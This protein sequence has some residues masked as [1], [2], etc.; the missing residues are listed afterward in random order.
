MDE[1]ITII[2]NPEM[3]EAEN[4]YWLRK[5]GIDYIEQ[6]GNRWW[7]DYNIHDPGITILEALSYALTELGYRTG[8]DIQDL[9]ADPG[10]KILDPDKQGFY[11]A[12]EILTV[13]PWTVTDY[14]KL[15]VDVSG[16]KNAWLI[17][18]QC[19]CETNLYVDCKKSELSYKKPKP[20]EKPA[21]H[22]V[23]PKGLYDVFL[24]FEEEEKAGDLNSGKIKQQ[25][26]VTINNKP[27][28]IVVELRLPAWPQVDVLRKKENVWK[29]FCGQKSSVEKVKATV[30]SGNKQDNIDITDDKLG[31]ALRKPMYVTLEVE[32][33]PDSS[34]PATEKIIWED[35]PFNLLLTAADIKKQLKVGDLRKVFEDFSAGGMAARYHERI[36]KTALTI[37]AVNQSLQSH[38]NL[39]ED[40]CTVTAIGIEEVAVC[41]DIE[42]SGDADIEK[43][44]AEVYYKVEN[45]FSPDIKFYSLKER[46][47]ARIPVDEIFEGPP[48]QFGF[49]DT[50]EIEATALKAELHTS[51]VINLLMDIEGVKAVKNLVL[52][53]YDKEGKA[54][55]SQQWTLKITPGHQPRLFLEASKFLV[56]KNNLTFLPDVSELMDTL[57]VIRGSLQRP[58]LKDHDLNLP[59][60][61]GKYYDWQ[62]YYPVQ[63]SFPLT[64][65]IGYEGLP[66]HAGDLRRAQASQ[67]KSYLLFYEQMLVN[68][69]AQLAHI[70][71]LFALDTSVSHSYFSRL[72]N[73]NDIAG[74]TSLYTAFDQTKL[75][76]LAE[77]Q[78]EFL[79]RRNRF[80]DHLLARFAESFT[81]YTLLLY[82]YTGQGA[83]AN[84]IL[85][86]DK[87]AF[88]KIYPLISA[89]RARAFNYKDEGNT[90]D[91]DNISGLQKRISALLGFEQYISYFDFV[92]T[93]NSGKYKLALRSGDA[94][95]LES[96]TT[97]TDIEK[98]AGSEKS[99]KI[100]D[101]IA[102]HISIPERFDISSSQS[103]FK[104]NLTNAGGTKIASG[105]QSY[106][107]KAEAEQARDGI[108][109]FAKKFLAQQ[110]VLLVEHLLLRPRFTP[111]TLPPDGDALL[112]VCVQPDCSFCGDEDPYSFRITFVM[113]GES[114]LA[115]NNILFRRFAE[116]TIRRETPAHIAVKICW[117]KEPELIAFE[118]AWCEWLT[119]LSKAEPV[120]QTLSD[121]L[122]AV[123]DLFKDLNSVYPPASLHDCVDGNDEN[124]V[125]LDQT[126]IS[127][128]KKDS[129]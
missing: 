116:E 7:T 109:A 103:K 8:F 3:P 61:Q 65:G 117:V 68:Y 62:D 110:Q 31:N 89:A 26:S 12:R 48:L 90:C 24:E 86:K 22:L 46:M 27:V 55:E 35:M 60:P 104:V 15:L 108:I 66:S 128:R 91:D 101:D 43:V 10:N 122:K 40:F 5:K 96:T 115:K 39:C 57:T 95:L 42:L 98:K 119:E 99:L 2:K 54:T 16:I 32:F 59:V 18:K 92:E 21:D 88:L 71:D 52:V 4:Y 37:K 123:I 105:K 83:V 113:N 6:L 13:N 50:T 36:Q 76:S 100:M 38:R 67:L 47:A 70:K 28:T 44:L 9:L 107:T 25:F 85:L 49:I 106:A 111:T 75:D 64:Y 77:D 120:P 93:G 53:R 125:Y 127:K 41:A 80:M 118:K 23:I 1:H 121:K 58:K 81:D 34:L 19:A 30:I 20:P 45:Y 14:R 124:R 94:S 17:C 11:T 73:D 102:D 63:Y 29:K 74:V 97:F 129:P 72:F 82:S 51:D 87:I 78:K 33:K 112:P 69:L 56:F 84:D 79:D 126:I 114:G